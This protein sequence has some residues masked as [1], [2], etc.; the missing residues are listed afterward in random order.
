[1]NSD[2]AKALICVEEGGL[3]ALG[4]GDA[5]EN[6]C[7]ANDF[8]GK[9]GQLLALPDLA[10]G[11]VRAHLFGLGSRDGRNPLLLGQAA[12]ALSKGSYRLE[13]LKSDAAEQALGF[14][15]GAYKF[16][17]S[18]GEADAP[19]LSSESTPSAEVLALRDAA[20]LARDLINLPANLLGPDAYATRVLEFAE[21]H[22]MVAREIRGDALLDENFPMI[23]AVGR[24]SSQ[25]PRLMDLTWGDPGHPKVTLVGK[26]VTFDT[27]GLDLKPASAMALMKKDM[28]GSANILGLAH[29]IMANRLPV[30]LRVLVP[31]VE[32]AVSGS[33]FRPGDV[34]T[35]RKGITVEIGNTDAE[36]RLILADALALATE[37]KPEIL[38]DMATL[39]GAARIAVGFE[40]AALFTASDPLADAMAKYGNQWG[41][42][43]W[44]MP[45]WQNYASGMKSKVADINHIASQS[46]AGAIVAAL[47]LEKFTEGAGEWVHLDISGWALEPRPGRPAGG[48]EAGI[49]A[50]YFAFKDRFPPRA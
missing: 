50:A 11:G 9:S 38:I 3:S 7:A 26:G 8:T 31:I 6:W 49:R 48:T 28:G 35:S 37:E 10:N 2:G 13:G 45:L 39:T 21:G 25:A 16:Q 5:A 27:G 12:A 17:L 15:L 42:P 18:G 36:G 34:L 24:A 19:I 40:L 1:M 44:R 23:H 30:R 46:Y 29:V 43:V 22:K 14:L 33:A 47:F 20:F 32:N 4:L 41:D